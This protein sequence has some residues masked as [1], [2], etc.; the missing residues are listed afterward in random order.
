MGHSPCGFTGRKGDH[1][2]AGQSSESTGRGRFHYA[3]EKA[4]SGRLY[5][6]AS[7]AGKTGLVRHDGHAA[8]FFGL[9]RVCVPGNI[10]CLSG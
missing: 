6:A 4:A 5:C 3:S 2:Y 7:I 10:Y 8:G 9:C 1:G